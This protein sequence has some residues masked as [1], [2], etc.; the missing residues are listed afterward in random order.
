MQ[1]VCKA[2]IM[3][4]FRLPDAIQKIE[5]IAAANM[6]HHRRILSGQRYA[7][8]INFAATRPDIQHGSKSRHQDQ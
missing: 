5:M 2:E 1:A 4:R 6:E 3:A 8:T 7:L